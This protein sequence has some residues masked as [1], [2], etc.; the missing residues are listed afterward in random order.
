[1]LYLN[2]KG[3]TIMAQHTIYLDD[4]TVKKI[5][6]AARKEHISVSRWVKK[7]LLFS[8]S[9]QWPA[10]YESLFGSL[11]DSGLERPAQPDFKDN[12]R[13]EKL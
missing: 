2:Q 9:Y 8:F 7:H 13:H 10:H 1:M 6:Q 4:N 11:K 3:G 5:G 12:S